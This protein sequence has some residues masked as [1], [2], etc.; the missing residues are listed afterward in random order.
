MFTDTWIITDGMCT[1]NGNSSAQ[2][3][4]DM[5]NAMPSKMHLL[6]MATWGVLAG[7]N[8]LHHPHVSKIEVLMKVSI[9]ILM[10]NYR[11]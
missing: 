7:A 4:G 1:K 2:I 9:L 11:Q 5:N 8:K 6:G 3:I 10:K